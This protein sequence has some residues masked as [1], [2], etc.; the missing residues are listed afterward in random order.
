MR[1]FIK[2]NE[3]DIPTYSNI[4]ETFYLDRYTKSSPFPPFI[5]IF[6][7]IANM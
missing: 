6:R 4:Y 5:I 7:K 2:F 3:K 1:E